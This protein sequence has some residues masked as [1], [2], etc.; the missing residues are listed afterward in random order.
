MRRVASA[1]AVL[2]HRSRAF[3][4]EGIY[5]I[6]V[7]SRA[8]GRILFRLVRSILRIA[9]KNV[10]TACCRCHSQP[11]LVGFDPHRSSAEHLRSKKIQD[12]RKQGVGNR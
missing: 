6:R 9:G 4:P 8:K 1:K 12:R 10:S 5:R 7:W 2:A 11:S 3:K